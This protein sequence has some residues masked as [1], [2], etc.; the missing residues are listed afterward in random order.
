MPGTMKTRSTSLSDFH[1]GK[2]EVTQGLWEEVMGGNP[3]YNKAGDNYPVEGV[4][5]ED[6][7]GFIERLNN[8]TGLNFRL[9]TEA[10]WEYAARGGKKSEGYKYAGSDGLDEVGWYGDNSGK[11]THP[12]G[13]KKPNELGLHDMSGNVWE[14]CQ[15]WYGGYEDEAQRDPTGPRFGGYRVLRGGSGWSYAG[16]CRVSYRCH[17]VPVF[18]HDSRGLRLALS[19]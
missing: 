15:D 18:R 3:S 16:H 5:W 8:R 1:I 4:S 6:C 11:H 9:P 10:E 7:Q 17:F 13:K 12:V 19:L 14:W 2:H